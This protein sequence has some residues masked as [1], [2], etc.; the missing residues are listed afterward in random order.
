M[1]ENN[2]MFRGTLFLTVSTFLSQLLGM[3]YI[4]PFYS[5][6]GGEENLALYGY[7]YTPYT[8]ML[9]VAAAGVPGAVSKFVAK[10]NALGAY[11]TSEKLYRSSL[12]VMLSSGI[13]VFLLLWLLAPVIAD[14]QLLAQTGG[15]LRWNKDD[16]T[17]IIRVI[18]FAVIVVP[19]MATWRGVFQ[20]FE[21]FGPTSV[22][23]VV[24]QIVRITVLLVGS[25]LAIRVFNGSIQLGNQIAVFAAFIAALAAALVL[26][27]FW[28]KRSP[29]IMKQVEG[30]KTGITVSYKEM[31]K[32]IFKSA[33]PFIVIGITFPMMMFIDQLTHNNALA[34]ANIDEHYRDAWFGMLNITTQK[35]VMIPVGLASAFAITILP[36]ITKS[37]QQKR[38]D[39]LEKQVSSMVTMQMFFVIPAAVGM[40]ILATP[41]Y[42]SFYS[43]NEMGIKIL[44]FYAPV[45][46]I[47]SLFSMTASIVQGIDKQHLTV[48]V[49]LA[50]LLTKGALNIP[51]I[52]QFYTVG[53][54]MSTI[55]AL[56]IGVIINFAIIKKYGRFHFR[57]IFGTLLDI[58]LYSVIMLLSVEVVYFLFMA[59]LDITNRLSSVL[60]LVVAVPVGVFVYF[61]LAFKTGLADKILGERADRIR[62][63]VKFL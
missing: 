11:Q 35:L 25:F 28:K 9:S 13:I 36:F 39:D 34:L 58:V 62:Q 46:I 21:S 22:S 30:D 51:M 33:V 15:D 17:N 55:I 63:R 31:Y 20:G 59:N 19:F 40:M 8:I 32:E 48:Y 26:F 27:I 52:T 16:I 44:T 49:V 1:S 57:K 6:M 5:I 41:L 24:E 3:L 45:C 38:F 23:G 43:F 50:V 56:F 60:L 18:A 4:I 2:K 54:V 10:Y 12:L 53:A 61:L 47:I 37:Y 42:T 7:A 29:Y 14:V